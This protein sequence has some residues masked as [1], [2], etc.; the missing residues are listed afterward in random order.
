MIKVPERV[1]P[2]G[3]EPRDEGVD[4]RRDKI[5]D[6]VPGTACSSSLGC[7]REDSMTWTSYADSRRSPSLT[8]TKLPL[9]IPAPV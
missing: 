8:R 9:V 4:A 1:R 5:L 2:A 6:V 3:A 7:P